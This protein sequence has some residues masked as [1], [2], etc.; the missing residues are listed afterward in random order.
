MSKRLNR[1]RVWENSDQDDT[2]NHFDNFFP[3]L[4]RWW[5]RWQKRRLWQIPCG[6]V[7]TWAFSHF[8]ETATTFWERTSVFLLAKIQHENFPQILLFS[9]QLETYKCILS[10]NVLCSVH[11]RAHSS[12]RMAGGKEDLGYQVDLFLIGKKNMNNAPFLYQIVCC[13]SLWF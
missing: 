5:W 13:F 7:T 4:T 1:A 10:V 3:G 6:R 12:R 8:S 2:N 9:R 11:R